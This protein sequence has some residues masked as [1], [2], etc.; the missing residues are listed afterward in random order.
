MFCVMPCSSGNNISIGFQG[1]IERFG[2][3]LRGHMLIV[4]E[5]TRLSQKT[6]P[7]RVFFFSLYTGCQ[8]SPGD[9]KIKA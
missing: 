6:H 8:T 4:P 5:K 1:L 7:T 9:K 2:R 3:R